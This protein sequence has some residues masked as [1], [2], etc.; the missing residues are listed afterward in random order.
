VREQ[1]AYTLNDLLYAYSQVAELERGLPL[2][3]EAGDLWRELDNR[4]M[5][6]DNLAGVSIAQW[7][8]GDAAAGLASADEC[9]AVAESVNNAWSMAQGRAMRGYALAEL[10]RFGEALAALHESDKFATAAE[11]G[12]A[13]I[14]AR[15]GLASN[16]ITLGIF[17]PGL[18]YAKRALEGALRYIP[19]WHLW[20]HSILIRYYLA[21]GDLTA[22]RRIADESQIT[23]R[24]RKL[25]KA[26]MP[27][28]A[29]VVL[30]DAE[31]ALADKNYSRVFAVAD[32]AFEY[33]KGSAPNYVPDLFLVRAQALLEQGDLD[34]AAGVLR[35][36]R[37]ATEKARRVRWKVLGMA[38]EIERRRG[39]AGEADRLRDVA[40]T[41]AQFIAENLSDE[42]R[43]TFLNLP[44]VRGVMR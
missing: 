29:A 30:A 39:N 5:L 41:E 25:F 11:T 10:G 42:P 20:P 43:A 3:I 36:A 7:S 21:R 22:A 24:E 27:G 34:Q 14:A 38:S 35:D 19:D 26:F 6:A 16:Y 17:E 40:R 28:V 44:S 23:S 13:I 4:P 12:G 33:L 2:R 37:E 18:E 15:C 8:F 32:E 9:F 31:L 1:L